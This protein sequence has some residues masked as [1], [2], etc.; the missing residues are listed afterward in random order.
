M[1]EIKTL[2]KIKT[3][4]RVSCL[5]SFSSCIW[6]SIAVRATATITVCERAHSHFFRRRRLSHFES[7]VERNTN[8]I[9]ENRFVGN[10]SHM[11][12]GRWAGGSAKGEGHALIYIVNL[13]HSWP[14]QL[15]RRHRTFPM[16]IALNF[17][18]IRHRDTR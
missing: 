10:Y 15:P 16:A 13:G 1:V 6:L 9:R 7:F 18:R 11:H 17:V 8:G 5:A 14:H 12:Y 2:E 3:I 4:L